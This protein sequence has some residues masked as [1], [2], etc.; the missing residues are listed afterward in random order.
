MVSKG[1]CQHYV[2]DAEDRAGPFPKGLFG[3]YH[4][5]AERIPTAEPGWD[6]GAGGLPAAP[7]DARQC[8]EHQQKEFGVGRRGLE[9]QYGYMDGSRPAHLLQPISHA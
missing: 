5:T 7:F 3:D 4:K 9:C 1:A 8:S 2:P 6:A